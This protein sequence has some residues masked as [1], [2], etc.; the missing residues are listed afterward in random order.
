VFGLRA[1][2]RR[3][4]ACNLLETDPAALYVGWVWWRALLHRGWWLVTSVYLV[5][6][7][8]LSGAQLVGVGVAQ[9]LIGLVC[10]IPA[11]AVADAVSRRRALVASQMLMGTAMGVTGLVT[12]YPVLV[13]TQ[14]L[15]GVSWN[16]A[17]GADV[18]WITDELDDPSRIG[19]VLVRSGRAQLTG[20]AVGLVS[21]GALASVA[22]RAHA[23]VA[24]GIAM[25]A[26]GVVVH[27][28]FPERRSAHRPSR[29]SASWSALVDGWAVVRAN[30]GILMMIA[31]TFLVNG[32]A[33]FGLL[34]TRRLL[35]LGFPATP[36]IW[37]TALGVLSL[38]LGAGVFRMAQS[39]LDD[40]ARLMTA[41]AI[42]CAVGAVSVAGLAVAPNAVVGS[43][44]V[45]VAGG[46][47]LPLTATLGTIWVNRRATTQVRATVLS[48][49]GLAEFAAEISFGLVVAVAAHSA[50]MSGALV[51]CAGLFAAGTVLVA[52]CAFSL[53]LW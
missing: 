28:R 38:L 4:P 7:A 16:L 17:S 12:D 14:M 46:I 36:I 52:L 32:A 53:E 51:A 48:Y 45:V 29:M 9:A 31:I 37:F 25:L 40:G 50:G 2:G 1:H 30:R 22:G 24:A 15:W 39:Y 27:L 3:W 6:D 18:A 34:Q 11:G 8:R 42:A 21:V 47:T 5:A 26:L 13:A 33:V 19:R 44:C 10:E 41:Y 35:Q 49:L 20:A 43:A 23:M